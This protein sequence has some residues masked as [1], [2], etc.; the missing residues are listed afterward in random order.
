M[1]RRGER[2]YKLLKCCVSQLKAGLPARCV[3]F[4]QVCFNPHHRKR[5]S[6][7]KFKV[8]SADRYKKFFISLEDH[9]T[10]PRNGGG[11]EKEIKKERKLNRSEAHG[12][13]LSTTNRM[14]LAYLKCPKTRISTGFRT[15]NIGGDIANRCKIISITW[16]IIWCM[17]IIWRMRNCKGKSPNFSV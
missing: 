13:S 4:F 10:L 8:T 11:K 15:K 17:H 14:G 2:I 9:K 16:N 1:G 6:W 3:P 5:R 7:S 12:C